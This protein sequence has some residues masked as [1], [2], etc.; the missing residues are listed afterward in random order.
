M[1][2][3][4]RNALV[5]LLVVACAPA[6][7]QSDR[8]VDGNYRYAVSATEEVACKNGKTQ[9]W[10][11][12]GLFTDPGTQWPDSFEM[13]VEDAARAAWDL[14]RAEKCKGTGKV[15]VVMSEEPVVDDAAYEAF[16]EAQRAGYDTAAKDA[17]KADE[18][19]MEPQAF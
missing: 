7:A 5:L 11:T 15:T 19:P 8:M 4:N 18:F 14:N 16:V 9:V 1:Q 12:H 6:A 17:W 13:D 2:L 10:W 3:T